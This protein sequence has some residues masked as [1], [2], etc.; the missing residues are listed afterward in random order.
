MNKVYAQEFSEIP[1]T[2]LVNSDLR[3]SIIKL[4]EEQP[5]AGKVT[6]GGDRLIRFK[7]ILKKLV[8]GEIGL[9]EAYYQTDNNIPRHTSIHN[10]NNRVFPT[11]WA[12]RLVRTQYSRFYN[13]AVL[14]QL[15]DEGQS[16]CIVPHSS[17]EERSSKCSQFLAGR[18]HDPH[19]LQGRL[20]N[21]YANG[22]W[23]NDLKIPDHPHCSHVV[24]P[25]A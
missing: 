15:I 23:N 9:L 11:G 18:A 20:T 16:E 13:Q 4:I 19:L 3:D 12:E 6:E 21:A 8:S 5:I 1:Q 25:V 7:E 24:T 17:E 2:L 14:K 22:V 10:G